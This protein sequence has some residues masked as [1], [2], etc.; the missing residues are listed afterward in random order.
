L[1]RSSVYYTPSDQPSLEEVVIINK[2]KDIWLDKQFLGYR[3]I[4]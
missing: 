1:N 3:R 2:I 4:T